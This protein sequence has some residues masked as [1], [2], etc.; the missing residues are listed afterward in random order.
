[1]SPVIVGQRNTCACGTSSRLFILTAVD[2]FCEHRLHCGYNLCLGGPKN[3]HHCRCTP[4]IYLSVG[5]SAGD[6]AAGSE[7]GRTKYLGFSTSV[8]CA[9]LLGGMWS[10]MVSAAFLVPHVWHP[11]WFHGRRHETLLSEK[12]IIV[13]AKE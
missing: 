13:L 3:L 5:A 8:P 6:Q 2:C 7:E 1:M 10:P 4:G 9:Y 12:G 11:V